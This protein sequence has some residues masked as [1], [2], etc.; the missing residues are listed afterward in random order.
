MKEGIHP[1]FTQTTVHCACGHEFETFSSADQI[2]VE[3]CSN[4]H[5][6]Y[7]GKQKIMDTEGRVDKFM[8]RYGKFQKAQAQAAK[9][10]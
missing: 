10:K 2:R 9:K 1:K 7:T 4:C 6:F 8:Q 5:P 3:I